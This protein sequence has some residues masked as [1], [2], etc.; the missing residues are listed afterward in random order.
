[1]PATDRS[2]KRRERDTGPFTIG[3]HARGPVPGRSGSRIRRSDWL[4][5]LPNGRE[6]CPSGRPEQGEG[7][8]WRP[9]VYQTN[10]NPELSLKMRRFFLK[11]C[12][13][14]L[15]SAASQRV[16]EQT[17]IGREACPSGRLEPE[18]RAER[19]GD[20]KDLSGRAE[21][22]KAARRVRAAVL[23]QSRERE[24]ATRRTPAGEWKIVR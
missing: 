13:R 7:P 2:G 8:Q 15:A 23:S 24:A 10:P 4:I 1:M 14:A 6:A 16:N 3:P 20:A 5:I 19:S 12:A 17:Q 18:P 21:I 11:P 9:K 22:T